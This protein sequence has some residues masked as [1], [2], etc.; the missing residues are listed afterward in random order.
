MSGP[1]KGQAWVWQTRDMLRSAK[2]QGLGINARRLIDFLMIENMNHGGKK[3]GFLLAPRDQL[4]TFGIGYRHITHAVEQADASGF[5]AVKIGKGRRP[6]TFTLTWLPVAGHEGVQQG[7]VA[8]HEG[9]RQGYTKV[10][11]KPRS[12]TR[13]C[14]AK[15]RIKGTPS[16]TPYKKFLPSR[17]DS[18]D[19]SGGAPAAGHVDGEADGQPDHGS[20]DDGQDLDLDRGVARREG[21]EPAGLA[22]GEPDHELGDE[23]AS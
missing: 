4:V 17:G 21:A 18:T 7:A 10:S 23:V 5:V 15:A 22:G 19:L 14:P 3:N 12:S 16:Y 2:W 1:P 6:S 8:G 13:R 11:S 20:A 9:V